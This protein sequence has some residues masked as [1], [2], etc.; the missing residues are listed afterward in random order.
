MIVMLIVHP[1]D[2]MDENSI[3]ISVSLSEI[4]NSSFIFRKTQIPT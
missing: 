2:M 4:H 1:S 3:Q